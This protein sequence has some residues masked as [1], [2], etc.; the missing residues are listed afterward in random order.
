[1]FYKSVGLFFVCDGN[2]MLFSID[3]QIELFKFKRLWLCKLQSLY[4]IYTSSIDR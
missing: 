1:M 4:I 3:L 2:V